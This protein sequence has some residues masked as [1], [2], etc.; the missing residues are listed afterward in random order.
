MQLPRKPIHLD[1]QQRRAIAV[2]A[3]VDPK[4]VLRYLANPEGVRALSRA[5][6]AR[7]AD[8][9]GIGHLALHDRQPVVR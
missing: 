4:T 9:L 1:P 5:R 6:I 2:V 7:A 8:K 3:E